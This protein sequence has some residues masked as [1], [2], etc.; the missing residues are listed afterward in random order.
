M[1]ILKKSLKNKDVKPVVHK[2]PPLR[3]KGKDKPKMAS[4]GLFGLDLKKFMGR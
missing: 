4:S 3:V 1:L 2:K